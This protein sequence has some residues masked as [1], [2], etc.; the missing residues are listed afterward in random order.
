MLSYLP[1]R[2]PPPMYMHPRDVHVPMLSES[3]NRLIFMRGTDK[4][5][6]IASRRTVG[7]GEPKTGQ[8]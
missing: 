7:Q 8:N 6:I 5:Y 2:I 4:L 1:Y 3:W